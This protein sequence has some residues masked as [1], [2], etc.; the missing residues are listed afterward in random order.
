MPIN[1]FNNLK[2]SNIKENWL[3]ELYNQ[4]SFLSFDGVNDYVDCGTTTGSS[5]VTVSDQGTFSFWIKFPTLVNGQAEAIFVNNVIESSYSGIWISKTGDH[6]IQ[7]HMMDG[8]GTTSEDRETFI[9]GTVLQEN[10]WYNIII[11]SNFNH[12][13]SDV[14][15][16]WKIYVNNDASGNVTNDGDADIDVPSYTTGKCEFGRVITGTDAYGKF[17]IKNFAVWELEL[18]TNNIT[19]IY[20]SGNYKSLLYDFGNYDQSTNLKAYWEFN[21][22]ESIVKDLSGNLQSGTVNGAIYRGYLPISFSDTVVNDIFYYGVVKNNPTIRESIDLKKSVSKSNNIS[23]D[24]PNFKYKGNSISEELFGGDSYYINKTVKVSSQVG[25][26][27][28]IVIGVFRLIDINTDGNSVSLSLVSQRPWD[29]ISFPQVKHPDYPIYEPVVYGSYT[30]SANA[31]T[32][33]IASSAYGG[34]FPVPVLYYSSN[35]VYTIMPRSYVTSDN[36]FLH[37]YVGYNQFLPLRLSAGIFSNEGLRVDSITSTTID[38]SGLNILGSRVYQYIGGTANLAEFDGY[39]STA[40]SD[41]NAGSVQVFD[42]QQNMFKR[43]IDGTFN[44]SVGASALFNSVEDFYCIIST[45]KKDMFLDNISEV[46]LKITLNVSASQGFNHMFSGGRFDPTDDTLLSSSVTR[47]YNNSTSSGTGEF[48]T[49]TGA[50]VFNDNITT[51]IVQNKLTSSDELLVKISSISFVGRQTNTMT[52]NSAEMYYHQVVPNPVGVDSQTNPTALELSYEKD[53]S[54]FQENKFFYCGGNGL[55]GLWSGTPNI[56]EIHEAHRDLLIRFTGM[57]ID[58]PNGW[59]DLDGAKDWKIRYWQLEP[60]ELK[61]ELEQL[62]YE[63]GFIFRYKNGN[64]KEPQYIFIKDSYS[65]TDHTITKS[66]ISNI[67]IKPDGYN[68]L[69]S[70]MNINY[71][72]HPSESGYLF[73]SNSKNLT[74]RN[75]YGIDL[76]ENIAEVNLNAYSSPEIPTSPSSSPND[77]FYTYYD[78]IFGDVKINISGTIINPSLYKIDVG[79]TVSFSDMYP[80]KAFGKSY[81][82]VVFMITSL[83]RSVGSLKFTVREIGVIT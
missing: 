57:S 68:S 15:T 11:V 6:K 81:T 18:S 46:V 7:A 52:I 37:K 23:I 12:S 32:A 58:D 25:N 83:T 49:T 29:F 31:N 73:N 20:N 39:I 61:K 54:K 62:Q 34:V 17:D 64:S 33:N 44:M 26:L 53:L 5:A 3:F 13:E 59:S 79:D 21:N 74:T 78:N 35:K 48:S 67:T 40:P 50:L 30:P 2:Q 28:P 16:N 51:T 72:K 8:S 47:W 80:D 1:D 45:P 14:N 55:K 43:N 9:S 65:S 41:Q 76:K 4:N 60:V 27:S 70:E 10:V 24:I 77:D 19:A 66:D 42:N 22:G 71:Q 69:L 36:A 56:T 38:N 75:N 82:D 63:G